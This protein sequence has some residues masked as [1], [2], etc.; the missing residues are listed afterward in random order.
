M[1]KVLMSGLALFTLFSGFNNVKAEENY[2]IYNVGDS[3]T[4]VDGTKWHVISY[5][6]SDSNELTLFSDYFVK[7]DGTQYQSW[8]L[9]WI[10]EADFNINDEYF[11]KFDDGSR[12]N[13]NNTFCLR[14]NDKNGEN[15]S[16]NVYS[17]VDGT[18]TKGKSSGTVSEDSYIKKYV[19]TKFLPNFINNLNNNKGLTSTI[20]ARLITI[21]EIASIEQLSLSEKNILNYKSLTTEEGS[22]KSLAKINTDW[23]KSYNTYKS[24]PISGYYTMSSVFIDDYDNT[25]SNGSDNSRYVYAIAGDNIYATDE[26]GGEFFSSIVGIVG[27]SIGVRPVVTLNKANVAGSKEYEELNSNTNNNTDNNQTTTTV[28][29]NNSTTTTKFNVENPKTA[30]TGNNLYIIIGV[31]ALVGITGLGVKLATSKN[32]N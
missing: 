4:L 28:V 15:M 5:S 31:I 16:C 8:D 30:D 6:G 12:H 10:T 3:I 26:L 9:G 21:D 14:N 24:V 18:L 19:D 22:L 11:G 25:Y 7:T 29:N 17:K 20:N 32:N 1:K 27:G 2:T 23:L 13:S